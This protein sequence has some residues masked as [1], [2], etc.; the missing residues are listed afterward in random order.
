MGDLRVS[1]S[2][3]YHE[4]RENVSSINGS[5]Y[6]FSFLS[7][8]KRWIPDIRFSCN[9][10]CSNM[11]DIV[12]NY[13]WEMIYIDEWNNVCLSLCGLYA[14]YVSL[15][16][17]NELR[18][19]NSRDGPLSIWELKN[20]MKLCD[21]GLI[22][23][24]LRR[25][26]VLAKLATDVHQHISIFYNISPQN[27]EPQYMRIRPTQNKCVQILD[28]PTEGYFRETVMKDGNPVII[29]SC[30][31]DWPA[32]STRKWSLRYL[33]KVAGWRTVPVQ[34]N[35]TYTHDP[36]KKQFM[37]ISKF[38]DC[39]INKENNKKGYITQHPLFEQVD[40]LWQDIQLPI[41]CKSWVKP[42]SDVKILTWFGPANSRS[43][44]RRD[45]IDLLFCQVIGQKRLKL[46]SPEFSDKMP[47]ENDFS[48]KK[49]E[50]LKPYE[51]CPNFDK[52]PFKTVLLGEGDM[53][54]I[55]AMY[56]FTEESLTTSFSVTFH[57]S[58]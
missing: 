25:E 49:K 44:L 53:L 52:I 16:C 56:W 58:D 3:I 14:N 43:P 26:S 22:F 13:L 8:I 7:Y 34:L 18:Y 27:E 51:T 28:S 39:F 48:K 30:M 21:L 10:E 42:N 32:M 41:Y 47:Q 55:P 35:E 38:I 40:R 20:L 24:C 4:I 57:P 37:S 29:K 6:G 54:Y 17:V 1:F 50:R 23:G 2:E 19:H 12:L 11:Y 31:Q 36:R 33:K 9:D 5:R 46:Y 15:K 45:G